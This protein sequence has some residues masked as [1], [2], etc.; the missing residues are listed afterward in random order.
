MTPT[1]IAS[2]RELLAKATQ[3][4]W[5]YE[6]V[7]DD[8]TY[9]IGVAMDAEDKF[10]S[11]YIGPDHDVIVVDTVGQEIQG[12][13]NASLIVA[14]VNALPGLLDEVEKLRVNNARSGIAKSTIPNGIRGE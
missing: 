4:E 8:N 13:A 14:A 9:A 6:S 2:F 5:A 10:V 12:Y 1:D 7:G 11:G 3:G